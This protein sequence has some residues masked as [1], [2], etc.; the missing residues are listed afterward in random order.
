M[1]TA[2]K[3]KPPAKQEA[4]GLPAELMQ[5]LYGD[6]GMGSESATAEDMS[7]PFVR[8]AQSLSAEISKREAA[9]IPG[10]EEGDFYN[11]ATQQT[12]K[13]ETGFLFVPALFQRKF[14]EWTP[15]DAGGG[16]A[17]EH[18]PEIMDRTTKDEKGRD[19]LDNGNE[20][21]PTGTWYGLVLDE[22]T[23]AAQQVVISLAKTQMKVSRQLMTKL[24]TV[25]LPR[26]DGKGTFNP[27]LFY[28]ALRVTSV[29]ESND[30]GRWMSFR[31]A[32]D[33][34]VLDRPGG[35]G[36]YAQA[37]AMLEAVR[38]GAIKAA[39]VRESGGDEDDKEIPF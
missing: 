1:N 14:L 3:P 33:G 9:Y 23:G 5:D 7:I 36:T 37:K 19:L 34:T 30:Q 18:G 16:F 26:P 31:F 38:S 11:T 17:G 21:L 8:C 10:L 6:A 15:R 20:I 25:A 12:W 35:A 27:P 24:K 39:V 22:E 32:L 28:N 4:G 13:G 29:P 2:T